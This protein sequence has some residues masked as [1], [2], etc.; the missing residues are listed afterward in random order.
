MLAAAMPRTI[1]KTQSVYTID[2]T[3]NQDTVNIPDPHLWEGIN[4]PGGSFPGFHLIGAPCPDPNAGLLEVLTL[5]GGGDYVKNEQLF[6]QTTPPP[7]IHKFRMDK[8]A[9]LISHRQK[10]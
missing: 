3:K 10:K 7:D 8:I 2:N 6:E 1:P 9:D 5:L 4:L